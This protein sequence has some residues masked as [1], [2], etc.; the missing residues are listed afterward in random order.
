MIAP[1]HNNN[2]G[3]LFDEEAMPFNL[4]GQIIQGPTPEELTEQERQLRHQEEAKR[5]QQSL[6]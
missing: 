6:I 3:S 1:I 2:T 5:S 4:S